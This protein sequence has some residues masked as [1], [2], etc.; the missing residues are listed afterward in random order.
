MNQKLYKDNAIES[1]S[2]ENIMSQS[3][4]K[5]RLLITYVTVILLHLNYLQ[6]NFIFKF[7]QNN[8]F[9]MI[10]FQYLTERYVILI[11]DNISPIFQIWMFTNM[12]HQFW[13]FHFLYIIK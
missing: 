7:S 10:V 2:F 6:S 5:R 9:E 4:S 13:P 3:H 8:F 12:Q 1:I 11:T